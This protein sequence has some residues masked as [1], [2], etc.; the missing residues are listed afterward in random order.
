MKLIFLGYRQIALEECDRHLLQREITGKASL[1]KMGNIDF[2]K[3]VRHLRERGARIDINLPPQ[4]NREPGTVNREPLLSKIYVLWY[5]LAGTYY[6]PGKEKAAL[7]GFLRKRFRVDHENFLDT[8]TAIK[9][10]EAIKAIGKRK[11]VI[12]D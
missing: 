8:P 9:V 11:L 3:L 7:R 2:E 10:I 4:S 5:Q 12:W 1:K 6:I